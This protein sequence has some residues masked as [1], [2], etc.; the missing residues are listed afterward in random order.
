VENIGYTNYIITY[1]T[2]T[3]AGTIREGLS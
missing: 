1:L 2:A 3:Y